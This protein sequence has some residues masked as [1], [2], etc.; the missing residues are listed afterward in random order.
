M[1]IAFALDRLLPFQDLV[2]LIQDKASA[3]SIQLR[4]HWQLPRPQAR[5]ANQGLL[6]PDGVAVLTEPD[7]ADRGRVPGRHTIRIRSVETEP[8]YGARRVL[9]R[10]GGWS[11]RPGRRTHAVAVR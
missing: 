6:L 8:Q 3:F 5:P 7:L 2:D 9:L 1:G 11:R 4:H 10:S